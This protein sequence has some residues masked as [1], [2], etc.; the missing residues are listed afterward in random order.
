MRWLQTSIIVFY[1]QNHRGHH[2]YAIR[3]ASWKWDEY[4]SI[5][6]P[7][8][9]II[10]A[11]IF[12]IVFHHT[13]I[14][15]KHCPES[16]V[17]ILIGVIV[18]FGQWALGWGDGTTKGPTHLKFTSAFFFDVLLPPLVLD[19]AYSLYDR[20]FL[21]NIGS[22]LIFAVFGTLFNVFTI[23]YG[24]YAINHLGWIAETFPQE[25]DT[26]QCLTFASIL[27][28]YNNNK[29]HVYFCVAKMTTSFL[30]QNITIFKLHLKHSRRRSSC[31]VGYISRDWC[32]HKFIFSCVWRIPAK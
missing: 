12:K 21:D 7:L 22:I 15:S 31:S 14:V 11:G 4:G 23:G 24:L 1:L 2:N 25:L 3:L 13:P 20:D 27:G 30:F 32:Q 19:S 10:M 5:L 18:G 16:C 6:T 29:N 26:F 28:R 17:L 9:I 8:V